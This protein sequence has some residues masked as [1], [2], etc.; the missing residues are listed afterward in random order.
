METSCHYQ[1]QLSHGLD[2]EDH[3]LNQL[4]PNSLYSN[5]LGDFSSAQ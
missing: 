3:H 2:C 4:S 5:M 1:R